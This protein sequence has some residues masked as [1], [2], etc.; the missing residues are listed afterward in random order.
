M[1]T[2]LRSRV[3][4]M[5]ETSLVKQNTIRKDSSGAYLGQEIQWPLALYLER[6]HHGVALRP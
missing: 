4:A 2:D 3:S 1:T 5:K 6:P